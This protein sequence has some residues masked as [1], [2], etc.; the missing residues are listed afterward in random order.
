LNYQDDGDYAYR[1]GYRRAGN[2]LSEYAIDNQ[3]ADYLVFPIC[4]LSHNWRNAAGGCYLR[5][6]AGARTI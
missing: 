2:L 4:P 5:Y 3:E 6:D 1:A